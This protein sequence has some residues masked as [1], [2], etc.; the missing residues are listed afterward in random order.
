MRL[1]RE[2]QGAFCVLNANAKSQ[3][4]KSM[5]I[6]VICTV[7]INIEYMQHICLQ[8]MPKPHQEVHQEEH[9]EVHQDHTNSSAKTRLN[10]G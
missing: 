3:T 8:F 7:Y 10:L 1:K 6:N 9:Q 2:T 5:K 4:R